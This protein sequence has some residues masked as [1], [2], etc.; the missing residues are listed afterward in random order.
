MGLSTDREEKENVSFNDN[1]K[2]YCKYYV[3]PTAYC[4]KSLYLNYAHRNDVNENSEL[5]QRV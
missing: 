5:P 3:I 1:D 2:L 4:A